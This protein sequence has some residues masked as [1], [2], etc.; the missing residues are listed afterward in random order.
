MDQNKLIEALKATLIPE[1]REQAEAY[2][3]GVQK[4]I[5]FV[6]QL[7]Q[8]VMNPEIDTA[9]RQ[10]GAIYMKNMMAQYWEDKTNDVKPGQPIPFCIHENDKQIIRDNIVQAII[11]LQNPIRVQ[12]S[13]CVSIIVKNDYPGKCSGIIEKVMAILTSSQHDAY[14]G[15]LICLYQVVKHY[16]YK[17][18]AERDPL[19]DVMTHILPII[20]QLAATLLED[21]SE[22]SILI[23]KQILKIFFALVQ[24]F[25]PLNLINHNVFT[26]WMELAR[27]ITERPLPPHID[28]LDEDE[29]GDTVWWKCKKWAVHLM[30][31]C[32]ER[33]GSPGNVLKEYAEFSEYFLKTFSV[34][35][36]QVIMGLLERY[37][38]KQ[39][40]APRVLQLSLQYI[41]IGIIHSLT[42]KAMKP[43]IQVV[44]QDIIFPLLGHTDEDEDLWK[45]DPVEYIKVKYDI[46]EEFFSPTTAAQNLLDD[47]V[48]KRK[49]VLAKTMAFSVQA[50][51]SNE[52]RVK[53]Q[54][55]HMIGCLADVLLKKNPYKDQVEQMLVAH[56]FPHF[57]STQGFLR[58]RACWMMCSFSELKFK[59]LNNL[60]LVTESLCRLLNSDK[61]LPVR[62]EAAVGLQKLL[63]EQ[64]R[65]KDM[66]IPCVHQI[67]KDLLSLMQETE[68]DNIS[69]CL[70]NFVYTYSE[71]VKPLAVEITT[72]LASTFAK[73]VESSSTSESSDDKSIVIMGILNSLETLCQVVEDQKEILHCIEG[74]IIE[75]IKVILRYNVSEYF[76]EMLSLIY[77]LTSSQVSPQMWDALPIIYDLFKKDSNIDYFSDM[78]PALHNYITVDPPAFLQQ[79]AR[80]EIMYNMAKDILNGELGDAGEDA[81][82]HAAKLLEIMLLQFKDLT[83]LSCKM[84]P[85]FIQL[86]LSRLSRPIQ[87]TELRTMCLQVI[88]ASIF[89]NPSLTLHILSEVQFSNAGDHSMIRQIVMQVIENSDS[90]FGVHDRKMFI[91]GFS[92]LL[93]LPEGARPPAINDLAPKMLSSLI[94][95][96]KGIKKAYEYQSQ[97][98]EENEKEEEDN[99][100]EDADDNELDDDDDVIDHEGE[101]YLEKMEKADEGDDDDDDDD[102][103]GDEETM[104]ES[105]LTVL[106]GENSPFEEY[107]MFRTVVEGIHSKDVMWYQMLTATLTEDEK[108]E[109]EDIF[110]LAEQKRAAQESKKIE[111]AG[112]YNFPST[113]VPSSFCFGG[114]PPAS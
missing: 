95:V 114:G 88:L 59:N 37:V 4:I 102:E 20:H 83:D 68:T 99:D 106:D 101:D 38:K 110:R 100:E 22:P 24:F 80:I 109:L 27:R 104:L 66:L 12:L 48:R 63:S 62:V 49:E 92:T 60:Q 15:A 44:I 42:W 2:L 43:H 75:V 103:D 73:L 69:G 7:L 105:Y 5:N 39:F 94:V 46:Y 76:E 41:D 33:Y 40:V 53:D 54:A 18:S 67:F 84:T 32:F 17:K 71:E 13:V 6:P 74:I 50:L 113:Q 25:L 78:M 34:G 89:V 8:L 30:T 11:S 87:T 23:Q 90:F 98:E 111:M 72:H 65:V 3:T 21:Q 93:S 9:V 82:S 16:E 52:E 86:I 31:R 10:S 19:N 14:L 47:V 64:S 51:M 96:F 57:A 29:R 81:E 56:V 77:S 61:D 35:C 1:Q 112:G 58:A 45:D 55:L 85:I 108:K 79:P 70:Q 91:L 107:Q 97:Q 36:L 28:E 26:Q